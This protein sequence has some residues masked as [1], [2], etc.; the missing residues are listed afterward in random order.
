MNAFIALP[1][2][3]P[4]IKYTINVTTAIIITAG[5]KYELALS[6]SFAIGAFVFVASTTS[7]TIS[8]IVE[9]FPIFS[10]LYSI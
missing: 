5:T 1:N 9:S 2:S 3:N 6:A 8:D 10:A 4:N 7:L